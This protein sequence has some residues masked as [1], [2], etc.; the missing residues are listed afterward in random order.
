MLI[1]S[2][3]SES[4]NIEAHALASFQNCYDALAVGVLSLCAQRQQREEKRHEPKRTC[5][6]HPVASAVVE[7]VAILPHDHH[8]HEQRGMQAQRREG[9]TDCGG[10]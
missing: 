10:S 9:L 6:S 5:V 7:T 1:R 3:G 8:A 2:G 4:L